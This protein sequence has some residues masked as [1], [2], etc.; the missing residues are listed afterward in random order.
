MREHLGHLGGRQHIS[1]E[2]KAGNGLIMR[3]V[4]EGIHLKHMILEGAVRVIVGRSVVQ[5]QNLYCIGVRHTLNNIIKLSLISGHTLQTELRLGFNKPSLDVVG[6]EG[7]S[8]TS[9]AMK[10]SAAVRTAEASGASLRMAGSPGITETGINPETIR[11]T[12]SSSDT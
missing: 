12:Q 6:P 8:L 9:T 10:R 7:G 3:I 1:R 5:V 11:K 2:G 4:R